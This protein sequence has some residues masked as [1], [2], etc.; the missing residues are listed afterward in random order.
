MFNTFSVAGWFGMRK[1]FCDCLF[2]ALP[3][4]QEYGNI[5]YSRPDGQEREGEGGERTTSTHLH[6]SF[7]DKKVKDLLKEPV[8][9]AVSIAEPD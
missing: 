6:F 3:W 1:E 9:P 7:G 4:L 2:S 8:V 5:S